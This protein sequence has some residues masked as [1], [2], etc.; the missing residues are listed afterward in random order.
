MHLPRRERRKVNQ[1]TATAKRKGRMKYI[2]FSNEFKT[3][4]GQ[5]VYI[6]DPDVIKRMHAEEAAF[7]DRRKAISEGKQPVGSL[8]PRVEATFTTALTWFLDTIPHAVEP[9]TITK[10]YPQG[11]P[12]KI[13]IQDAGN[14]YA[15][16]KE[17]QQHNDSHLELEDSVYDWLIKTIEL[18][19][20]SAF[21]APVAGM[22]MRMI[23]DVYN[24]KTTKGD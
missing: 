1:R 17:L 14:A 16:I 8:M 5:P 6:P 7:E 21:A 9:D 3:P 15:V 13:T 11:K 4:S 2:K 19:A 10:E 18:D 12:R 23:Q 22:L 24:P 20:T